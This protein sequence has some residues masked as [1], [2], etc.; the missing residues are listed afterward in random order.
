MSTATP[1]I[2]ATPG[3]LSKKERK[4]L[5]KQ[6]MER[7]EQLL[8]KHGRGDTAR[9]A[10]ARPKL[11]SDPPKAKLP[12]WTPPAQPAPHRAL[13]ETTAAPE[14]AAFRGRRS[15]RPRVRDT[16]YLPAS[17]KTTPQPAEILPG[18]LPGVV[19]LDDAGPGPLTRAAA[20]VERVGRRSIIL[21]KQRPWRDTGETRGEPRRSEAYRSLSLMVRPLRT[22]GLVAIAGAIVLGRESRGMGASETGSL[23]VLGMGLGLAV[24]LL[25]LAEIAGAL[26]TIARRL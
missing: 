23:V 25:A 5:R 10:S 19:D 13:V 24:V 3:T 21:W 1:G 12:T 17:D 7:K 20:A 14:P 22:L 6:M 2:S 9:A 8:A 26:R 18:E 11:P 15:L 4:Q 16:A